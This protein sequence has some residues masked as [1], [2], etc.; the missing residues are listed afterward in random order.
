M[1]IGAFFILL[2]SGEL[3]LGRTLWGS[4]GV[5]SLATSQ[6]NGHFTS[7]SFV[8]PYSLTHVSHG[9]LLF[10]AVR[11]VARQ[12]PVP[13]VRVAVMAMEGV[14][15]MVENSD[16]IIRRY[17]ATTISQD[18]Y[19]DSIANSLGDM[20]ACLVGLWAASRLSTRLSVVIFFS[21]EL[22]LLWLIKD[23]LLVNVIML[24]F[25]ISE[26]RSWQGL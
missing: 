24:I 22:A 20:L 4:P 12:M 26:I 14:W 17:R 16:F 2:V 10:G 11:L 23:S 6:A 8:D 18:Y 9:L 1:V 5:P 7:Q 15:E 25:P 13:Q 21:I 19:G 3:L